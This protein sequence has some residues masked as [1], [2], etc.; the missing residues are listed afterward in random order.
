MSQLIINTQVVKWIF[1]CLS[2]TMSLTFMLSRDNFKHGSHEIWSPP[3]CLL[4]DEL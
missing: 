1:M 4:Q 2:V 3:S